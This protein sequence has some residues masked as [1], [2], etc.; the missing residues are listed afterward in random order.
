MFGP[1]WLTVG[2]AASLTAAIALASGWGIQVARVGVTV[3]ILT[4]VAHDDDALRYDLMR[5]GNTLIGVAVGLAV[6]FFVWPV[7]GL[8][9]VRQATRN[10]LDGVGAA[11]RRDG[12]GRTA[13][14]AAAGRAARRAVR[15]S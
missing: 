10:V 3:C 2:L 6:S 5:T 11:A 15:A 7:R 4:L 13:V 1:N 12:H 8:D 14:A 9:Q